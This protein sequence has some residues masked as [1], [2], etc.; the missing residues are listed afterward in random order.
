MTS[1]GKGVSAAAALAATRLRV[2][3]VPA[4]AALAVTRCHA[5]RSVPGKGERGMGDAERRSTGT[6]PSQG[7]VS[8]SKDVR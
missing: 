4:A 8:G 3:G 2:A 6:V 1:E 7:G 5:A